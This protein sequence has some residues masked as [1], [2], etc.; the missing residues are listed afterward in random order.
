[1]SEELSRQQGTPAA[2]EFP[3]FGQEAHLQGIRSWGIRRLAARPGDQNGNPLSSGGETKADLLDQM[4]AEVA[5]CQLCPLC[6]SRN[7]TAFGVGD[8]D[9]ELMFVGEAPGHEEDRR[10]EPFVGRAGQLLDRIIAALGLRREQVYIANVLKCRPPQN[11]DP[12]PNETESCRSYLERQIQLIQPR[13]LVALGRPASC[14]LTGQ[15]TSLA[16]L[17]GKLHDWQG[18]PVLATY[19]PAFLL[20]QEQY[21]AACWQDFQLVIERLDLTPVRG[22]G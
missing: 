21:K 10:G 15:E 14:W 18:I 3:H 22:R 5:S 9:A 20:R 4:A 8:P 2:A 11:R 12:Q 13:M 6:E 17:R 1:M 7:L 16:R 19:H